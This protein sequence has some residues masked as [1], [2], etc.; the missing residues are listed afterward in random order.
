MEFLQV[1]ETPAPEPVEDLE[2]QEGCPEAQIGT[3]HSDC[4]GHGGKLTPSSFSRQG[5]VLCTALHL[6]YSF[7]G[8]VARCA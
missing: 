2:M 3:Y 7:C 4:L 5:W 8:P 1:P 6:C